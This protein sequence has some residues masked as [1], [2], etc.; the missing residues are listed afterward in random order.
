[1]IDFRNYSTSAISLGHLSLKL[2]IYRQDGVAYMETFMGK[3]FW[4][5]A[6]VQQSS[7]TTVRLAKAR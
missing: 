4:L 7:L 5:H 1:M 3:T 6:M 2:G